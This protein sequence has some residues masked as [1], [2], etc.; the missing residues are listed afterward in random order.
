MKTKIILL[1]IIVVIISFVAIIKYSDFAFSDSQC[2]TGGC[3]L[4]EC[5]KEGKDVMFAITCQWLPEHGCNKDCKVRN[6]KCDFDQEFKETCLNCIDNCKTQIGDNNTQ[7][8]DCYRTCY[9][10]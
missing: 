6:F 10:S 3:S 2:V 5:G 9:Q 7:L 1:I 8:N 4:G